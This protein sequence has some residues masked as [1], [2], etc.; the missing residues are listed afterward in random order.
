LYQKLIFISGQQF[1]IFFLKG[2]KS[3]THIKRQATLHNCL[4]SLLGNGDELIEI[5]Y[6]EEKYILFWAD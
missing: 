6:G 3:E 2:I 5:V 4:S 1:L